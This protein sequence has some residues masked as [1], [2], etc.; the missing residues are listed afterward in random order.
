MSNPCFVERGD[1]KGTIRIQSSKG[2][3]CAFND[4]QSKLFCDTQ[5]Q[6][7]TPT[8]L[9]NPMEIDLLLRVLE[10]DYYSLWRAGKIN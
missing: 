5:R 10:V 9:N 3:H 2:Q 8:R 7:G 6:I 4:M 1:R